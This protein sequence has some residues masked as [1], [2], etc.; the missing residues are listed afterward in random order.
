[1]D[2]SVEYDA[3]AE[4]YEVWTETAPIAGPNLHFYV[5]EY[6]RSPTPVVELGIGNGRI[7]IEAA[8]QGKPIVG[9]DSSGAMLRLCRERAQLAGVTDRLTLIQGDFRDFELPELAQLITIPFHTIGHLLT[10]A[11][12]EAGLR[13]IYSQLAPGGRLVFDTFVFDP[14]YAQARNNVALLRAEYVDTMTGQDVLLWT[15][16]RY[17]F[18]TQTMRIIT[19]TDELDP[20]GNVEERKYRFLS[21]SWVEPEQIRALLSETGYQIEAVYGDFW[22]TPFAEGAAEQVWVTRKA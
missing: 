6:L 16:T 9:V 10:L 18:S 20:Q 13:H 2:R 21:F 5:E 14:S 15:A 1:M 22:R 17:H 8:L 19:W 7:A 3:F 4:I 12:K 11:D